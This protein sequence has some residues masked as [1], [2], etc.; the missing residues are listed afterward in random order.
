MRGEGFAADDAI[1]PPLPASPAELSELGQWVFEEHKK[2]IGVRRRNQ[3]LTHADVEVLDKEN[4]TISVR[5]RGENGE[6]IQTD[7]WLEPAPGVRIRAGAEVL[8]EWGS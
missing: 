1:R 2:L 5:S 8:Y 6:E 7:A 4:A 3:W